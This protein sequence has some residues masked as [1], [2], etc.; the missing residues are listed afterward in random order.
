MSNMESRNDYRV[1]GAIS[2]VRV[3]SMS[4]RESEND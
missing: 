3:A 1:G 2:C 4:S